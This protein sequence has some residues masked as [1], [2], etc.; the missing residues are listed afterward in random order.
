MMAL[1]EE[2]GSTSYSELQKEATRK[3]LSQVIDSQPP[4][5][6]W[7]RLPGQVRVGWKFWKYLGGKMLSAK[8][9]VKSL[10]LSDNNNFFGLYKTPLSS[11]CRRSVGYPTSPC[12]RSAAA[13]RAASRCSSLTPG[14]CWLP[15]VPTGTLSPSSVGDASFWAKASHVCDTT[16]GKRPVNLLLTT[17]TFLL[18]FHTYTEVS[19][20][21]TSSKGSTSSGA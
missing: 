10:L 6:A 11:L 20:T 17:D 8:S 1:Q 21:H 14:P 18:N 2:R 15:L 12:C 5:L 13:R 19:D 3:D 4:V 9:T 16:A 7:S